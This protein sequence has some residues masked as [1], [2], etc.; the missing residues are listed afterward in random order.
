[1]HDRISKARSKASR[2]R[3]AH[4]SSNPNK[5]SSNSNRSAL[6]RRGNSSR[7][8]QPPP[9]QQHPQQQQQRAQHPQQQQHAQ[10]P[11]QQQ[12]A[13]AQ[14]QQRPQQ[15]NQQQQPQRPQQQARAWQQQRGW[16]PQGAWQ[17]HA[18]W[19]QDRAQHW[20]T[21]HRDW[22]ERGGYGGYYVPQITYNLYFG[23]EHFFRLRTLPVIFDGYPRFQY[24]GYSFL[25]VDPY[26]ENWAYDWYT[27]DDVYIDYEDGYYLYDTRYPYVR[28]AVTIAL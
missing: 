22:T 13:Q 10:Q 14:Q 27:S 20:A 28:L 19:Q 24:G 4:R 16:A 12:R 17:G 1:M 15:A 3:R 8:A 6:N 23:S 2:K 26:P 25:L 7:R 21:D 5:G 18:T 11:Q 9:Q